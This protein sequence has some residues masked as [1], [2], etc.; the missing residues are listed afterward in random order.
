MKL[1]GSCYCRAIKYELNLDSADDAR[2]SLCHCNNCKL[3]LFNWWW[4]HWSNVHMQK[5]FGTNYGLTAKVPKE[6]FQYILGTPKE[7]AA[8]NGSGVIIY[9][10]F[11]DVCGSFILEYGVRQ[12]T[13]TLINPKADWGITGACKRKFSLYSCWQLGWTRSASTKRRILLQVQSELDA[14]DSEYVHIISVTVIGHG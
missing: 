12:I 5:A 8:D 7:H 13:A 14:R 6:S 2:T 4:V 9:R 10:E 3:S 1:T 11:C